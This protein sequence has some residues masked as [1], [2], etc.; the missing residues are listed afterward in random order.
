MVRYRKKLPAR[1]A[2]QIASTTRSRF[3]K[4]CAVIFVCDYMVIEK[5][6]MLYMQG[7]SE[8]CIYSAA[9]IHCDMNVRGELAT[10]SFNFVL[11]FLTL[12]LVC[13]FTIRRIA[14]AS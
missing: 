4:K 11:K 10:S 12:K 3:I 7:L 9:R 2:N 13:H 6:I 8:T 14:V 5:N 1:A